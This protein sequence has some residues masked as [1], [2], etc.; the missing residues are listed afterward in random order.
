MRRTEIIVFVSAVVV[1]LLIGLS[2]LLPAEIYSS[3][4]WHILWII[5]AVALII[6]II[7]LIRK[8]YNTKRTTTMGR[9]WRIRSA[10]MMHI[11]F[12]L[13]IAGGFCT[14]LFSRRGTLHLFPSQTADCFIS[15][16]GKME[17]L[18]S[19]VTLLSFAPE[20]YP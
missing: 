14:S 16:D 7:Y 17:R 13:M 2:S 4:V 15:S 9:L 20:Y 19:A 5:I 8:T 1:P 3:A 18:P 11:A 10:F 6:G 12:L